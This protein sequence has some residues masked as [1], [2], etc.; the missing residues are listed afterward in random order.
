MD[1]ITYLGS[2]FF[3][4]TISIILA[5]T[6]FYF[7]YKNFFNKDITYRQSF[8]N[9][10]LYQLISGIAVSLISRIISFF[11]L[12]ISWKWLI[13]ELIITISVLLILFF[14]LVI[15]KNT[16]TLK[17]SLLLFLII[18]LLIFPLVSLFDSTI[19]SLIP[20]PKNFDFSSRYYYNV[21]PGNIPD[22]FDI[23]LIKRIDLFL[24]SFFYSPLNS[25][26][27]I[28]AKFNS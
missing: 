15:K 6:I 28:M 10:F 14:R 12:N 9:L 25:I 26:Q 7:I 19:Q 11:V 23:I 1:K 3:C 8:K 5:N 4:F 2:L 22:C 24:N 16:L 21:C 13:L 27:E 17:K 18:I 20:T